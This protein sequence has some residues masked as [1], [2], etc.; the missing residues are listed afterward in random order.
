[1]R[2]FFVKIPG[3]INPKVFDPLKMWKIGIATTILYL[4]LVS[5]HSKAQK[6]QNSEEPYANLK[7]AVA[8]WELV[9]GGFS[10]SHCIIH[11]KDNLSIVYVAKKLF[12]NTPDDQAQSAQRYMRAIEIALRDLAQGQPVKNQLMQRIVSITPPSQRHPSHYLAASQNLRCQRGV[13]IKPALQRSASYLPLIHQQLKV[14]RMPLEL[15]Y[16]PVLESGFDIRAS[17]K[18]GAKGLWQLMPHT[19]RNLG[20]RVGPWMDQRFDPEHSTKAALTY[21]KSLH[22]KFGTWPLAIT[23]YNYGENGLARAVMKFGPDFNAIREKHQTKIFGFA[24]RNYY[25]S[26]IALRNV[27]NRNHPHIALMVKD[28][29]RYNTHTARVAAS[30]KRRYF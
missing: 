13:D 18:A 8:F 15:A 28:P 10:G 3:I 7:A 27:I 9:F 24:A 19:A 6:D 4:S 21:L 30:S 23:A 2:D 12:G 1:M 29:D 17:S 25:A 14:R 26:F 16:L 5:N 11:D 22:D 20:L